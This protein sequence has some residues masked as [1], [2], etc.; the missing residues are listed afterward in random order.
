R[1][2]ADIG[3]FTS[4]IFLGVRIECA[5]CHHHPNEKWSQEDFYQLAAFFGPLKRKGQGISAPI[6]GEAEFVWFAPGGGEVKHPLTGEVLKPKALEA[7]AEVIP[8]DRDP[9]ELLAAWMT[10]PGNPFFA[11]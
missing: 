1:E 7:P 2:P 8:P 3:A 11:R 10:R 6:S 5:R 9:R 4:Q